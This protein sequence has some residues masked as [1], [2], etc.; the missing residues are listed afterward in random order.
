MTP[1]LTETSICQ[2]VNIALRD[3]SRNRARCFSALLAQAEHTRKEKATVNACCAILEPSV[4]CQAR[5]RRA[6][7]VRAYCTSL[8]RF[9]DLARASLALQVQKLGNKAAPAVQML[10]LGLSRLSVRVQGSVNQDLSVRAWAHKIVK[11]AQKGHLR[12]TPAQ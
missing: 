6:R 10:V 5:Y 4:L 8:M 12:D 2:S 7:A 9:P 3:I 11:L 1:G